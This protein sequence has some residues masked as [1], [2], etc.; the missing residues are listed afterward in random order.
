VATAI[1]LARASGLDDST[2]GALAKA[3]T[4]TSDPKLKQALQTLKEQ[5]PD[6]KR[7]RQDLQQWWKE[8]SHEWIKKL[9]ATMIKYRNI[10][11]NWQ[12]SEAQQHL[13]Q[14]YYDANKLLVD[15]LNSDCHI[16]RAVREEIEASLLLPIAEIERSFPNQRHP[17]P[18]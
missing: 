2:N 5:I 12:F 4:L 1:A 10:G 8:Y 14:Q 15:C 17:Q 9:R 6:L 18:S 16:S 13:F 11:N 7:D 3:H